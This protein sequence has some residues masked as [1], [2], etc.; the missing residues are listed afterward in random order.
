MPNLT[1]LS[2][3]I[4]TLDNLYSLN[5]LHRASG[6]HQKHKPVQFL[7]NQQT[8]D[9]INEIEQ[10]ANSHFAVNTKRGGNNAGTWVCKELV[11]SYA[12]WISAKFQ[13]QVIK[14]FDLMVKQ[15]HN[16]GTHNQ[17]PTLLSNAKRACDRVSQ[18]ENQSY[19][20]LLALKET[21][22]QLEHSSRIAQNQINDLLTS[23]HSK[24]DH[25]AHIYLAH[26]VMVV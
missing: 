16:S 26:Q 20:E 22:A 19:N 5:D 17:N 8:Q 18:R 10:S 24:R 6:G 3:D 1:I 23:H 4:R 9:L 12:M 25:I 13:L 14:A 7:R 21:F 2:N 11:Y 15:N